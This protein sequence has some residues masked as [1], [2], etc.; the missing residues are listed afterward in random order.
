MKS[1]TVLLS[2]IAAVLIMAS[3]LIFAS[4]YGYQHAAMKQKACNMV[5]KMGAT[6]FADRVSKK[7]KKAKFEGDGEAIELANFAVNYG[8]DKADD[9]SDAYSVPWGRCMDQFTR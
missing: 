3:P 4:D 8:Y 7:P 1:H 9:I 5:G 2:I 6:A